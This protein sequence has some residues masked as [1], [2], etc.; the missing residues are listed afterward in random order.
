MSAFAAAPAPSLTGTY[1]CTMSKQSGDALAVILRRADRRA[2]REAHRQ[3]V[4]QVA[5]ELET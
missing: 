3:V 1:I 2:V 5:L 4:L